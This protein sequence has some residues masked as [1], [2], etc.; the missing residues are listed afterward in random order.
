MGRHEDEEAGQDDQ[1]LILGSLILV[2]SGLAEGQFP[3]NQGAGYG[4]KIIEDLE[5]REHHDEQR[6]ED[7]GEVFEPKFAA[8][9]V[10]SGYLLLLVSI[11][12][13]VHT[14]PQ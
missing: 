4:K 6:H 8:A 13:P 7:Q 5:E 1:G 2:I 9:F 3:G 12:R 14:L 10:P 11:N